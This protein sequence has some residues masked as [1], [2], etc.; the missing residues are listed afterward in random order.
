MQG[1][2]GYSFDVESITNINTPTILCE[3]K[4][5]VT[6]MKG[7]TRFAGTME[8]NGENIDVNNKRVGSNSPALHLSKAPKSAS[9]R[10]KISP[11]STPK[12]ATLSKS[13][14]LSR[15]R[16]K[17][18]NKDETKPESINLRQIDLGYLELYPSRSP[19]TF[20][21]SVKLSKAGFIAGN[22]RIFFRDSKGWYLSITES[23]ALSLHISTQQNINS[24]RTK[25]QEKEQALVILSADNKIKFDRWTQIAFSSNGQGEIKLYVNGSEVAAG[26]VPTASLRYTFNSVL[27]T[28]MMA[29]PFGKM[30]TSGEV[31]N[32]RIWKKALSGSQLQVN[33][34][35]LRTTSSLVYY[36]NFS[37]KTLNDQ[38]SEQRVKIKDL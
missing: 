25:E 22:R 11:K 2:K 26:Q 23:G 19:F 32:V 1:G 31:K 29:D 37:S 7:F 9:I 8:V 5:A 4:V 33:K 24:W 13:L 10:L 30:N 12:V 16:S 28:T 17:K 36:V 35:R 20:E 34:L 18:L 14:K 27:N 3:A 38:F 15:A 21:T 6:P